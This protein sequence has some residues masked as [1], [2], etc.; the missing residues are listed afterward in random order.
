VSKLLTGTV[1]IYI[2][3]Y[4]KN[5]CGIGNYADNYIDGSYNLSAILKLIYPLKIYIKNN[6]NNNVH[7]SERINLSG[8]CK[9]GCPSAYLFIMAIE[10]LAITIRSYNNIKGLET[11]GLKTTLS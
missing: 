1:Y 2:Y 3:I 9:Q 8:G 5:I 10:M 7:F 11:P 4:P 6:S